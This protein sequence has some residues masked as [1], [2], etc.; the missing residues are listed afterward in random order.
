MGKVLTLAADFALPP[1]PPLREQI[2]A[3]LEVEPQRVDTLAYPADPAAVRDALARLE[4]QGLVRLYDRRR[5]YAGEPPVVQMAA[6][7]RH[8]QQQAA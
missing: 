7:A 3:E 8:Q 6:L 2:L 5:L 4:R 1:A